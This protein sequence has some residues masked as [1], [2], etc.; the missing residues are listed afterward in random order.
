M[1]N[2]KY[3]NNQVFFLDSSEHEHLLPSGCIPITDEEAEAIRVAAIIPPSVD[4]IRTQRDA[5]ISASDWTQIPDS[6]FT[7]AQRETWATYRQALRDI[8]KQPG[9]PET[10]DWPVAPV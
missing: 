2:Y 4:D 10:I 8:T 3:S 6:P 1:P 5:L 7:K 9:F